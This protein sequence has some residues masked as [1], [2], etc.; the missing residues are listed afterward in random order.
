MIALKA[1]HFAAHRPGTTVLVV[2]PSSRQSE[3]LLG[4]AAYLPEEMWETALPML[5]AAEGGGF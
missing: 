2:A 4:I 1:A 5:N 3:E